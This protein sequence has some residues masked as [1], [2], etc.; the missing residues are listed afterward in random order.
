MDVDAAGPVDGTIDGQHHPDIVSFN[1]FSEVHSAECA[2]PYLP[3]PLRTLTY[4]I[5]Y[6][7]PRALGR[8]PALPAPWT[9]PL[10]PVLTVFA[11]PPRRGVGGR[12]CFDPLEK[13]Q[14]AMRKPMRTQ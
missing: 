3:L 14:W 2:A 9:L 6:T 8:P 10:S 7:L 11:P 12:G 5:R 13:R 1:Q 4:P